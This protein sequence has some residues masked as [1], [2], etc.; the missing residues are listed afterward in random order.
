VFLVVIQ[1]ALKHFLFSILCDF[2]KLTTLRL[3]DENFQ[4]FNS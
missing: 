4:L 2:S 3:L 1:E